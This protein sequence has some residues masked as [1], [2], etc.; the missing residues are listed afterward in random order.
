MAK[1]GFEQ[2]PTTHAVILE[3]NNN[4]PNKPLSIIEA[5]IICEPGTD[6]SRRL[7]DWYAKTYGPPAKKTNTMDGT[8]Q[9]G[10]R[11]MSSEF[12]HTWRFRTPD[13]RA[14]SLEI[15]RRNDFAYYTITLEAL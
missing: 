7:F 6:V 2:K 15:K 4:D 10:S 13:G 11:V 9:L 5:K 3:V 8:M 14:V 1:E 12:W